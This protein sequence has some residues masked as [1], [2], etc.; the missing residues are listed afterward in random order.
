MLL[1]L[2]SSVMGAC[3]CVT[4]IQRFKTSAQLDHQ[5]KQL[6]P[7]VEGAFNVVHNYQSSVGGTGATSFVHTYTGAETRW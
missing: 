7:L 4:Q 5:L 2:I 1:A 3:A 6:H